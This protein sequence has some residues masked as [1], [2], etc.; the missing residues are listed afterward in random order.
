MIYMWKNKS[1]VPRIS[2][3]GIVC[4]VALTIASCKVYRPE[5][6]QGQLIDAETVEQLEIGMQ[7]TKVHELMGTPLIADPFNL[8]RW[9][10]VYYVIDEDG[11]RVNAATVSIVFVDGKVSTIEVDLSKEYETSAD[12]ESL[13]KEDVDLSEEE[14]FFRSLILKMKRNQTQEPELPEGDELTTEVPASDT[15]KPAEKAIEEDPENKKGRIR[16]FFDKILGKSN[17]N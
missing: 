7:Y 11:N 6:Q 16:S 5:Q 2:V 3:L 17:E 15:Q 8:D 12:R 1:F 13:D 4:V 14:S 9:D 10:Y